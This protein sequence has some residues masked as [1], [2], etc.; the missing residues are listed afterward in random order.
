MFIECLTK[1]YDLFLSTVFISHFL[2][3]LLGQALSHIFTSSVSMTY[4]QCICNT[5]K[6]IKELIGIK[7]VPQGNFSSFYSNWH[8]DQNLEKEIDLK[9][10][11]FSKVA[12]LKPAA[13]LKTEFPQR[14]FSRILDTCAEQLFCRTFL[15]GF[16]YFCR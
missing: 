13:L 4:F 7:V 1:L 6:K 3:V 11:S 14:F 12:N 10:F 16:F 5:R 15:G 8:F 9:M 2:W